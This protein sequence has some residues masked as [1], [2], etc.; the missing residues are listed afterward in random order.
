MPSSSVIRFQPTPSARRV[1]VFA[2]LPNLQAGISTHTLRKEGDRLRPLERGTLPNISTHTLRKEGDFKR[3]WL[4]GVKFISTHTLRKEGDVESISAC[5]V[6]TSF[7]PTPSAR[8]VTFD[9][10]LMGALTVFQP[11]PSA[12][13]V[14]S[15]KSSALLLPKEFQPTPSA[16]RVTRI[17]SIVTAIWSNFNPHPPQ[18][19]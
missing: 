10:P 7:Q 15:P 9:I 13:R 4:D 14:T 18:G 1:T 11:T 6:S 2:S 12:R 17:R 16:R 8:R 19:G 3:R 5:M